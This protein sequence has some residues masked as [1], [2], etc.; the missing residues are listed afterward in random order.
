MLDCL[1]PMVDSEPKGQLTSVME[2]P[3]VGTLIVCFS[4]IG[5][6]AVTNVRLI[7]SIAGIAHLN[8]CFLPAARRMWSEEMRRYI[9]L[10]ILVLCYLHLLGVELRLGV[11]ALE[12]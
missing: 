6:V 5:S 1:V 4:K 11:G 2:S 7:F 12:S 10:G 9:V 3:I 8:G